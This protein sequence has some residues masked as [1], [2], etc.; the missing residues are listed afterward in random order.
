ML[1]ART[2]RMLSPTSRSSLATR[3]GRARHL[4]CGA[5]TCHHLQ[6]RTAALGGDVT[7]SFS[8]VSAE[9]WL[10]TRTRNRRVILLPWYTLL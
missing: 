3:E 8:A 2:K 7:S 4:R 10:T 5:G 9:K 6:V 1:P